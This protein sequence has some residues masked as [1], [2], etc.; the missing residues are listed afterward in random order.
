VAENELVVE[1]REGAGKGAARKLRATGRIPGV[2]YGRTLPSVGI[3]LDPRVL[4]HLLAA[5]TA[6]MN[7]LFQ[8]RIAGVGDLDGKPVLVRE[9]QRN[10][11]NGW[12]LHADLYAVDLEQSIHVSVPLH[13]T[14][15]A[16]GV[17]M[18]GILDQALRTLD[19]E[20]MPQAIPREI[21]VE[22]SALEIG[23][24]LHVRDIA[25]PGGISLLSDPDLAVVSIVAPVVEEVAAPAEEE[26]VPEA[27][28]AAAEAEAGEAAPEEQKPGGKASGD[29]Q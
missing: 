6:G 13:I 22:V 14:G 21:S 23:Q 28:A 5:S 25:L 17:K 24:T 9:L 1:V 20:C 2:C 19:L 18:G 11:V 12:L 4:E 27:E 16:A 3:S 26:E 8:L 7:T 10:P 15:S 29:Q